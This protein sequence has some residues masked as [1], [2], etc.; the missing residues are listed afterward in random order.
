[1]VAFRFSSNL[2]YRFA[3]RVSFCSAGASKKQKRRVEGTPF[4]RVSN[5]P[6]VRGSWPA[7]PSWMPKSS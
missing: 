2:M 4:H 7:G 3:T 5:S 6:H 1:M